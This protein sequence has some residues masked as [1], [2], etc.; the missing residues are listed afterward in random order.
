MTAESDYAAGF[1]LDETMPGGDNRYLHVL[2]VDGAVLTATAVGDA[3]TITL[4]DGR[5]VTVAFNHSAPGATLAIAGVSTTL[6]A[7]IETLPE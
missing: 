5:V 6:D 7:S 2:S 4:A 1:R 3:A